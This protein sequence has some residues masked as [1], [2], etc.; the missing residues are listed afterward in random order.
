M[1]LHVASSPVGAAITVSV[2]FLLIFALSF[3]F[4][5]V[6]E[7]GRR[8]SRE[9]VRSWLVASFPRMAI[10]GVFAGLVLV[11]A[12]S[13]GNSSTNAAVSCDKGVPPL[14]GEAVTDDRIASA[15]LSLNVIVDAANAGD[16]ERARTVW[17][18]SDA[19]NLTHDIDGPLRALSEDATRALCEDVIALENVMVGQIVPEPV[20]ER[21]GAVSGGLQ[22]ARIALRSTTGA[23]ATPEIFEPC[24]LP[25]GAATEQPLTPERIEDAIGQLRRVSSLAEAGDLA[26]AEAAFAGDAHNITHDID[27]PLRINNEQLAMDLCL[28]V[29]EIE[30]NL[31]AN[32]DAEVI[33]SR[34]G[35]SADLLEEGARALGIL[36]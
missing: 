5:P 9:W 21:A 1:V 28:A 23:T 12:L 2:I 30:R 33:T 26:G 31:G 36:Q 15:V 7:S 16:V 25:V 18:T 22:A 34:A 27:G 19:H 20:I 13:Y 10:A 6:P 8:F 4:G 32:Y 24:R 17:L 35:E 29:S 11:A 3:A 14:S